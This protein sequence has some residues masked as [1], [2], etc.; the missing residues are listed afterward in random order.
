[1]DSVNRLLLFCSLYQHHLNYNSKGFIL[2]QDSNEY[3]NETGKGTSKPNCLPALSITC[4]TDSA[5]SWSLSGLTSSNNESWIG[6]TI[7][8]DSGKDLLSIL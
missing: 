4:R 2:P 7:L 5:T 8:A 3:S 1:M 6:N